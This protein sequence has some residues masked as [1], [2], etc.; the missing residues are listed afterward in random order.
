M[1]YRCLRVDRHGVQ[2]FHRLGPVGGRAGIRE[3]DRLFHDPR[4]LLGRLL[5]DG[6]DVVLPLLEVD[7]P[8]EDRVPALP[9]DD[10]LL[11]PVIRPVVLG[12]AVVPVRLALHQ[13]RAVALARP[14]DRLP[15]RLHHGMEVVPVDHLAL[16]AVP[17]RPVRHVVDPEL[18]FVGGGVGVEVVLADEDHRELVHAGEVHRLVDIPPAA[19]PLPEEGDRHAVLLADLELVGHPRGHRQC[20]AET[21]RGAEDPVGQ[22][23]AVQVGVFP[24]REA[25][26]LA[27]DLRHQ[28]LRVGPLDEIGAQVPVQREDPVVPPQVVAE[29]DRHRLLPFSR[30]DPAHELPLL[31]QRGDPA[32]ELADE[33]EPAVQ[34][35]VFLLGHGILSW[36]VI[37]RSPRRPA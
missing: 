28:P 35:P 3:R 22:V 23:A 16:E 13:R 25:V 1:A 24:L 12:V 15:G 21:G 9:G 20:R 18:Q 8:E 17:H 7:L 29:A 37:G 14:V 36:K 5:P 33:A 34:L 19:R 32:L 2:V 11:R 6:G 4:H 26:P 10:L 30:V 27:E 31:V